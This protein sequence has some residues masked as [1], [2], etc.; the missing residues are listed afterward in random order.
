MNE[1][2]LEN[3][4]KERDGLRESLSEAKHRSHEWKLHCLRARVHVERLRLGLQQIA[5]CVSIKSARKRAEEA[6][7]MDVNYETHD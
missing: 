6:L 3:L 7:R 5:G 4:R 2:E 1:Q